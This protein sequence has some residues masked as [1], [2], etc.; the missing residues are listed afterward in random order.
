MQEKTKTKIK[1][2]AFKSMTY[3]LAAECAIVPMA[4]SKSVFAKDLPEF[5]DGYNI[6]DLWKAQCERDYEENKDTN[7]NLAIYML[8]QALKY[9]K[10]S[11]VLKD[12][13]TKVGY[14]VS[15]LEKRGEFEQAIINCL[16]W[17]DMLKLLEL[18]DPKNEV[19]SDPIAGDTKV[20]Y[21]RAAEL[22]I[23]KSEYLAKKKII[24]FN[25]QNIG[26][27]ST[28]ESCLI[29]AKKIYDYLGEDSLSKECSRKIEEL[30]R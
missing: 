7:P 5:H 8:T 17:A 9:V 28:A 1:R 12:Y 6:H 3:L 4:F 23:K 25:P 14:C 20:W 13:N 10:T 15:L 30:G 11:S 16:E 19:F 18:K 2:A 27:N 26:D 24:K 22:W 29:E 21:L